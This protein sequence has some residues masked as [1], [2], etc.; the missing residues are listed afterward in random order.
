M[1]T[2]RELIL[3]GVLGNTQVI[4]GRKSFEPL[5]AILLNENDNIK[6]NVEPREC[7]KEAEVF[8]AT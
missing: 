1:M 3:K 8:A 2:S 6:E 4:I 7:H 5:K